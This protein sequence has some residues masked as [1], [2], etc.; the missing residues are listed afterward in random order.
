[1]KLAT[2]SLFVFFSE[3]KQHENQEIISE[4]PC[5]SNGRTTVISG[6][7]NTYNIKQRLQL[8]LSKY[9]WISVQK[10]LVLKK[11]TYEVSTCVCILNHVCCWGRHLGPHTRPHLVTVSYI[12]QLGVGLSKT[13][14]MHYV[15]LRSAYSNSRSEIQKFPEASRPT[16]LASVGSWEDRITSRDSRTRQKIGLEKNFTLL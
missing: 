1:M 16:N 13:S 8:I 9:Q 2:G 3:S 14:S 10:W 6:P 12:T 4:T 15:F 11:I 7:L 5:S